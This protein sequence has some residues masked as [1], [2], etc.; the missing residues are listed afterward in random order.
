MTI[1][2]ICIFTSHTSSS[3]PAILLEQAVDGHLGPHPPRNADEVH[4][5]QVEGIPSLEKGE[6]QSHSQTERD[7]KERVRLY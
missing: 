3:Y 6:K 2:I 5:L 4:R 1:I 7:P